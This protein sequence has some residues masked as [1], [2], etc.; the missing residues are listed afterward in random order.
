MEFQD[1]DAFCEL[2][3]VEAVKLEKVAPGWLAELQSDQKNLWPR[4]RVFHAS[5]EIRWEPWSSRQDSFRAMVVTETNRAPGGDG[6]TK[7]DFDEVIE[8]RVL[9]WGERKK[10][11]SY[12]KEER[13]PRPLQYP[14]QWSEAEPMAAIEARDYLQG[15]VIRL[16]RFVRVMPVCKPEDE[17]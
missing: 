11:D 3:K 15:G 14:V 13:I 16:T 17:P 4:G 9:L 12:W 6:W 2:E 1:C 8:T 5:V 7:H 10:G